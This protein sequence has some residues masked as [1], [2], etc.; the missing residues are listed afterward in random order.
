MN[1]IEYPSLYNSANSG[2]NSVQKLFFRM[3]IGYLSC[4]IFSTALSFFHGNNRIYSSI[5][6]F[7]LLVGLGF[8]IYLATK[9][10]QRIWYCARALAESIKTV[11]WRY[12]MR[13][14][15]FDQDDTSSKKEF[16]AYLRQILNTNKEV[17][18]HVINNINTFD[19]ITEKMLKNRSLAFVERKKIYEVQRIKEQHEWYKKKSSATKNLERVWF[20]CLITANLLAIIFALCKV[21]WPQSEYWPI[22][23]FVTIAGAIM[24]WLQT[25]KY[26]ELATSYALTAHEISLLHSEIP[27]EEC[28]FS[29]FVNN[30]ES[31]FS[32]EHTQWKARSDIE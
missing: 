25:K 7:I 22:D 13:A 30:S 21:I 5:Q 23:I 28:E 31:A 6:V 3:L 12:M 16:S 17:C 8:S 1:E 20:F 11:T 27:N 18:G 14:K 19:Q 32:R 4:L 15:P 24:T 2:A 9:K 10:P 29:C 26:Q